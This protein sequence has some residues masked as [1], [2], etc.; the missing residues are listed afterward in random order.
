LE[1]RYRVSNRAFDGRGA[2]MDEVQANIDRAQRLIALRRLD[3]AIDALPWYLLRRRALAAR[4]PESARRA[5]AIDDRDHDNW[6]GISRTPFRYIL[7]A[8][9]AGFIVSL[10]I[11]SIA[12]SGK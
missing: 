3:D 4:L 11:A 1:I 8:V 10:S 12:G 5:L 9:A 7:L 6:F 2:G